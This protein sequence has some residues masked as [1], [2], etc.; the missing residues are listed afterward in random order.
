MFGSSK[1]DQKIKSIEGL[2]DAELT[3]DMTLRMNSTCY[4]ICLENNHPSD[5][6]LTEKKLKFSADDPKT[7]DTYG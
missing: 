7:Q 6:Y 5:R 2:L 1:N 3:L 4:Q